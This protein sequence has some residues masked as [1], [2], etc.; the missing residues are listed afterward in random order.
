MAVARLTAL[1]RTERPP[2]AAGCKGFLCIRAT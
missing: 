2:N 1:R